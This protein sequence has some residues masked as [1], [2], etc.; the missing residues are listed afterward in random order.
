MIRMSGGRIKL[1]LDSILQ[2]YG[3]FTVLPLGDVLNFGNTG[4]TGNNHLP[5]AIL[6]S[7]SVLGYTQNG[8]LLS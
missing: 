7:F 5:L 3:F 8:C 6:M 4:N 1:D 2:R